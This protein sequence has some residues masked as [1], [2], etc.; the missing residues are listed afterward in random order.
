MTT[1]TLRDELESFACDGREAFTIAD[2][3]LGSIIKTLQRDTHI[4]LKRIELELLLEENH[5]EIRQQ[6]FRLLVD[7]VHLDQV[8]VVDGEAP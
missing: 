6:L 8:D 7:R 2:R 1:V 5:A 3:W 4:N